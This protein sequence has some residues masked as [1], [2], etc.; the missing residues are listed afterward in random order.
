MTTGTV[1]DIKRYAIHDGPGIR[2]TVFLKGCPLNCPWCHNPEGQHADPEPMVPA[3]PR[4]DLRHPGNEIVGR[5]MDVEEVMLEIEKDTLFFD[6]SGGGVTF[7]GG[8]PLMQPE[9][10]ESLLRACRDKEIHSV[11]DTCGYAPSAVFARMT[12]QVG[13]FLFDLKLMD[14]AEHQNYTGVSNRPI[15]Q[16][17][18]ALD[19][20]RKRIRIRFLVI[21]HITD[22]EDNINNTISFL[23][24]LKSI[25]HVSLLPYHKMAAE[26]YRRLRRKNAM[27]GVPPPTQQSMASIQTRF[28]SHGIRVTVGGQE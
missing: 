12:D 19:E 1:F 22:T 16:N 17:L 14:N 4:E 5:V 2:T 9:F 7:S 8:E 27:E 26:K 18:K 6:Q 11:L 3:I 21:P 24:S 20:R 10:L 15:L 28:E 23:T 13:L 25:D